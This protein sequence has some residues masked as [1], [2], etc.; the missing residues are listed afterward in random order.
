MS[1]DL[2][3]IE[4]ALAAATPG[5]WHA[6]DRG[7]GSEVHIGAEHA[8]RR[9]EGG[10]CVRWCEPVNDEFRETFK[11]ADAELI[12]LLR[13]TSAELVERVKA[14]EAEVERL[15]R[16]Q[17]DALPVID[18]LQ[19]L[20]RSLGLILGDSVTG[21][22]ARAAAEALKARAETAEA[23]IARVRELADDHPGT[24]WNS[25]LNLRQALRD[26]LGGTQGD[27]PEG[28]DSADG[29]V[30]RFTSEVSTP[31]PEPILRP[32]DQ[33]AMGGFVDSAKL[34]IIGDGTETLIPPAGR[35]GL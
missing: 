15:S 24:A 31:A 23:A 16:W 21:P 2:A 7:I 34:Y 18:G 28:A 33:R 20:G 10:R 17:S 32:T 26:V 12:A 11:D 6:W 14:A 29:E 8:E 22:K 4:A 25:G 3:V 1:T 5:P 35:P 30:N 9:Y 13:N 27:A 19:E